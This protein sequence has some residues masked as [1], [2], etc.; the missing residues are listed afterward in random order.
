[1]VEFFCDEKEKPLSNGLVA[2]IFKLLKVELTVPDRNTVSRMAGLEV[3][4]S[5]KATGKAWHSVC[6]S[7]VRH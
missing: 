6:D 2:S 3:G 1:M 5:L 4:L 7:T